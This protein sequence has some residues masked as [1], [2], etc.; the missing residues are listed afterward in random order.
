MTSGHLWP[1]FQFAHNEGTHKGRFRIF[2]I[3]IKMIYFY[4][5]M[6]DLKY[7][8]FTLMYNF[9]I[10]YNTGVLVSLLFY[11]LLLDLRGNKI[12]I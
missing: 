10:W 11:S 12:K 1:F 7:V 5:V 2:K 6:Y 3:N 4:G 9:Q 8:K